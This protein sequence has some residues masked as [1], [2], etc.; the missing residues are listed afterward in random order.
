MNLR[1]KDLLCYQEKLANAA[2]I[3]SSD[4]F[5]NDSILH[6]MVIMQEIFNKAAREPKNTVCMYCGNFSLFRDRTKSKILGEK[7]A[8]STD[9]LKEN[10]QQQWQEKD[11]FGDLCN[12]LSNFLNN[13]GSLKLIMEYGIDTLTDNSVWNILQ[14]SIRSKR[15]EIYALIT[16]MGLDHFATTTDAYRVENSDELKT[17]TC[18]FGDRNNA[19]VLNDNFKELLEL[20]QPVELV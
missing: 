10:E 15:T 9:D 19:N 8:C 14:P 5:F 17:A 18:C 12:S 4:I 6:A 13:Q 2:Q 16:N 3:G 11:F 7:M 1:A 20:S